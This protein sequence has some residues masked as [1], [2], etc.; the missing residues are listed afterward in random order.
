[1]MNNL[2][3]RCK[4][5]NLAITRFWAK[6]TVLLEAGL[7]YIH[8]LN[9]KLMPQ[10]DYDNKIRAY[11]KEQVNKPLP[12]GSPSGKILLQYFENLFFLEN[13]MKHMFIVKPNFAKYT[14]LDESYR[15]L[16]NIKIPTVEQWQEFTD[17]M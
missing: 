7:P 10:K 6:Y 15:K 4:D 12:Q 8:A 3:D 11:G 2:E 9:E 16:K 17:L 5:M 14:E 1:M 13:E